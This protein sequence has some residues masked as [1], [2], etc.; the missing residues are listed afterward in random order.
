LTTNVS[1]MRK[2]K[3]LTSSSDILPFA[4]SSLYP[5]LLLSSSLPFR[6]PGAINIQLSRRLFEIQGKQRECG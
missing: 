2:Y 6:K 4:I 3:S 1:Y 5:L